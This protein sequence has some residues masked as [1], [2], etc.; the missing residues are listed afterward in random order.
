M[1]EVG[2]PV[3]GID[4]SK[5]KLDI[6]L[7]V[8]GKLKS[9]VFPNSRDGYAELGKWLKNQGVTLDLVHVCME[10]TGVYSEPAALALVDLGLKVSVVNP[11]SVKG[12]GQ[13]L[14][15]RNKNDKADAA[16]I[17]RYCAAIQPALWQAPS[18]EQRQLRAWNEH[19]ASL[20]DIRQQ[21]ANRIEALEFANQGEVAA[22]AKTHLKWLD[23]E[24]KQLE[25]DIDDHIDRHPDLQRDAEL[26]ESI[27]GLGRGTAAKVLGR[28]GDLRRFGSAKEL[29]AY[30][31]VTPRQRQSGSS[32]RG[33]TTISRMGCRDLRAALYMPAMTAIRKNPLLS[34]FA[35]RLESS[36]M[37]KMAV[38]AA[39]MRKLVHQMYGVVRSGK[40]FDPNH[41]NK[42]LELQHGI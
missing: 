11:A 31:G 27:P 34:E 26:I 7:L 35:N 17:A 19:L 25:N 32:I 37:A 29:A 14:I 33:R 10:S 24:I 2:T 6:A 42:Q 39:V 1:N 16:V 12:F 20:K 30:I 21:Q 41:L 8:N 15:I 5:S 28:V 38:I 4:V 13:S 18:P 40:P 22:H 3:V 23:K 36:G 9:K